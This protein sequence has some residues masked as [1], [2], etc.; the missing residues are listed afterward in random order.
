MDP[1]PSGLEAPTTSG[2]QEPS[3]ACRL[4]VARAIAVD[5]LSGRS[6]LFHPLPSAIGEH[7]ITYVPR[8]FNLLPIRLICV[9]M[10]L[11]ASHESALF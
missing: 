5:Q 7:T 6:T 2:R 3:L 4:R 1:R 9:W 8:S 11:A 10:H